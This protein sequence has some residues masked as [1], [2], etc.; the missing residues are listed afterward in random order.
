MGD[1]DEDVTH[2]M[3]SFLRLIEFEGDI[4]KLQ[5]AVQTACDELKA[6]L[7]ARQGYPEDSD[8]DLDP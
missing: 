5:Q 6:R 2:H 1:Y 7:K 3:L 8:D 4:L